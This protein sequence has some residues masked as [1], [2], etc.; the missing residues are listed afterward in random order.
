MIERCVEGSIS[1][2]GIAPELFD[3][4]Q[5]NL[6]LLAE[7]HHG[8]D[9]GCRLGT[10]LTFAPRWDVGSLPTV[11][12]SI[13]QHLDAANRWLG[14]AVAQVSRAAGAQFV[15][16]V[17]DGAVRFC[18]ADAFE[19]PWLPSFGRQHAEHGFLIERC[20]DA[21]I[22]TDAYRNRTPWGEAEPGR[23][24]V[25]LN[26]VHSFGEVEVEVVT[27][28]PAPLAPRPSTVSVD[29]GA[30]SEYVEAFASCADQTAAVEALTLET[31]LLVRSR[32]LHAAARRARGLTCEPAELAH[33][34]RWETLAEQAYIAF[35]R[36]A[37]G[38]ADARRVVSELQSLLEADADVFD[39]ELDE[40]PAPNLVERTVLRTISASFG[41][42]ARA[43]RHDSE[44]RAFDNFTS[45]RLVEIIERI[46]SELAVEV[47]A[48]DLVASNLKQVGDLVR[49]AQRAR[50][51]TNV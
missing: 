27:L 51:V 5:V 50:T 3:C 29:L 41:L 35:R 43:I 31:W 9:T 20:D 4:L 49:I 12:P 44:L 36:A 11:A 25:Q 39:Y 22:A 32:H 6:A 7:H 15:E 16:I 14:L 37:R 38:Q 30:V 21:W 45:M 26:D 18:V 48:A 19:L 33:L 2:D 8:R 24:R 17:S 23:W 47:D 42:D 10:S 40:S 34:E 1:L 28:V 13:A 46:E